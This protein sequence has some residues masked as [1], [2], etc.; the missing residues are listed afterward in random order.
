MRSKAA[1]LA[2][3]VLASLGTAGCANTDAVGD[4]ASKEAAS[5]DQAKEDEVYCQ[6][7]DSTGSRLQPHTTCTKGVNTNAQDVVR[8]WQNNHQ[9]NRQQ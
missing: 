1:L 9:I 7:D 5:T 2:L 6:T 8:D 3:V 4:T